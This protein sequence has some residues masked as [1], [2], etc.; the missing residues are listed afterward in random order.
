MDAV[1]S[2]DSGRQP[3]TIWFQQGVT[4]AVAEHYPVNTERG[5]CTS[6]EKTYRELFRWC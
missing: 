2:F 5:M 6:N 4:F 1:D 3:L